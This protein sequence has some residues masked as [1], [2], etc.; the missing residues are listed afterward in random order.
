MSLCQKYKS[1]DIFLGNAIKYLYLLNLEFNNFA[2]P[3]IP[4]F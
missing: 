4:N 2:F 3:Y 1:G